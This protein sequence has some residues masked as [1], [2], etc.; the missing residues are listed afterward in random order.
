MIGPLTLG[1]LLVIYSIV[2][3]VYI[4]LTEFELMEFRKARTRFNK[5]FGR[6]EKEL[7]REEYALLTEIKAIRQLIDE[8]HAIH[9][10]GG[11]SPASKKS[12]KTPGV[13]SPPPSTKR[14]MSALKKRIMKK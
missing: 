12:A 4:V 11:K 2:L 5:I 8:L 7:E 1:D 6:E 9:V 10:P 14:T 13:P 3:V